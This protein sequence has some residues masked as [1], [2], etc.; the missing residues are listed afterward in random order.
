MKKL[1]YLLL[2]TLA[3]IF[4]GCGQNNKPTG[5]NTDSPETTAEATPAAQFDL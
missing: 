2:I 1:T 3:V 5:N 4:A